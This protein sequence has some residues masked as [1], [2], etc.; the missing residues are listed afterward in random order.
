MKKKSFLFLIL[1]TIPFLSQAQ[2]KL[3][4]SIGSGINK[5]HI[6][7]NYSVGFNQVGI[8]YR[9]GIKLNYYLNQRFK[10][11]TGIL[12]TYN[13]NVRDFNIV[14]ID[15]SSKAIQFPAHFGYVLAS[16]PIEI[17]LGININFNL[18]QKFD[19][20]PYVLEEYQNIYTNLNLGCFYTFSERFK[21]G[22]VSEIGLSPY[23]KYSIL[24]TIPPNNAT[25]E[26]FF[27]R[28]AQIE[29]NFIL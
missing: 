15:R 29:L 14:E 26:K 3:N 7:D 18:N 27:I 17:L 9:G 24:N 22:I 2:F 28:N 8:S 16:T 20:S 23:F 13:Q 11:G 4:L 19:P 10:I 25:I 1:L 6:K 5:T 12:Y 21:I